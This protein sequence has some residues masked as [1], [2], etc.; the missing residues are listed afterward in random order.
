MS[1]QISTVGAQEAFLVGNAGGN[2]DGGGGISE[3]GNRVCKSVE[4]K[5]EDVAHS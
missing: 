5:R 4:G 1:R 2:E 3:R